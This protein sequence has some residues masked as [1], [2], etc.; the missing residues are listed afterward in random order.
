[1]KKYIVEEEN[2]FNGGE[3][4]ETLEEAKEY[5]NTMLHD[6][7]NYNYSINKDKMFTLFSVEITE[8]EEDNKRMLSAII[9]LKMGSGNKASTYNW[10]KNRLSDTQ[11]VIVPRSMIDIFAK[12]ANIW[13]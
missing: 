3:E 9:G 6:L 2:N 13:I 4:F 5:F 7:S 12:A 1:M 11:G 8:D 10:F